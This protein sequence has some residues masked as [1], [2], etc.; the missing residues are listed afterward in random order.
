MPQTT[1]P[2][3]RP[4]IKQILQFYQTHGSFKGFCIKQP[5]SF[6]FKKHEQPSSLKFT[7]CDNYYYRQM[8]AGLNKTP[9]TPKIPYAPIPS[10]SSFRVGFGYL[11][12]FSQG[13][14]STREWSP[15]R[16]DSACRIRTTESEHGR[17][18]PATIGMPLRTNPRSGHSPGSLQDGA[19]GLPC[20]C[21]QGIMSSQA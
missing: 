1:R 4:Q 7:R 11:N 2:Q 6:G 15:D 20:S 13:I 19:L 21:H 16:P 14:W 18:Q 17:C 5:H 10:A 9:K 8:L 3:T 12:T